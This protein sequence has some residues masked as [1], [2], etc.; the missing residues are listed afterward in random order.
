MLVIRSLDKNFGM[1]AAL[2]EVNIEIPEGKVTAVI[3]PNG[4]GKTT[5]INVITGLF[6]PER[7]EV[8]FNGKPIHRLAP[9]LISQGGIARTF[10]IIRL[11]PSMT[12]L[13]NIM[14]GL[15]NRFKEKEWRFFFSIRAMAREEKEST[16]IASDILDFLGI[17]EYARFFPHQLSTGHLRLVEIGRAIIGNATLLLLDEPFSG[18]A[19]K[20]VEMLEGTLKNLVEKRGMTMLLIE[21]NIPV[22]MSLAEKIVV[23]NFGR[24]IAEGSPSEISTNQ[25]VIDAYLGEDAE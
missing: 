18:L 4:A 3:G 19:P 21:H 7:G 22:V 6:S 8:L 23:L 13:E 5:L 17:E 2:Q 16:R 9:H 1:I 24:K 20:E 12:V 11:I 14:V 10:Q 25:A 15:H